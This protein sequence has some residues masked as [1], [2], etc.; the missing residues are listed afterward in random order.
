[1]RSGAE[2][3]LL[4][5]AAF[6]LTALS[7][8]CTSSSTTPVRTG[9]GQADPL[10]SGAGLPQSVQATEGGQ[11]D[12][13]LL[14]ELQAELGRVLA[15]RGIRLDADGQPLG[16]S[17]S[18]LP[19]RE[20]DFP[21]ATDDMP[22]DLVLLE[23]RHFMLGD[24]D[25]NGEVNVSDITP[26]GVH[27]G[28]TSAS[29]DWADASVA[30][31]DGNGEVNIADIT[32]IGQNFGALL[33]GYVVE[34]RNYGTD[35]W[36]GFGFAPFDPAASQAL[37]GQMKYEAHRA[38]DALG[39][40]VA[41]VGQTREFNWTNYR[42][43]TWDSSCYPA[44]LANDFGT[45]GIAF[46]DQAAGELIY[47]YAKT[48]YPQSASDWELAQVALSDVKPQPP[49]LGFVLGR[50]MIAY[51]REGQTPGFELCYASADDVD[52]QQAT[53]QT[54]VVQTSL[55]AARRAFCLRTADR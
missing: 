10:Q 2:L 36:A 29:P 11:V 43:D 25:L 52:P 27:F 46:V 6:L 54:H 45:P 40:R 3:C 33:S 41:P 32:P 31:G 22:N 15:A 5:V 53:W 34:C 14:A 17:V 8:G 24:Y 42:L 1:M 37:G 16:K 20:F 7:A 48:S 47:G 28:K 26:V 23:W 50:P 12:P 38:L 18:S 51:V 39:F 44:V 4:I 55:P 9:P 19:R 35:D 30:D 49:Q 13:S 21:L